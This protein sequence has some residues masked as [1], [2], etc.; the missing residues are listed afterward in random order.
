MRDVNENSAED[1]ENTSLY[2]QLE[3]KLKDSETRY[4]RLFE[5]AKDGVLILDGNSGQIVDVNPYLQEL[6]GYSHN[7]LLGRELWEIG[8]FKNIAASKKAFKELQSKEY[9]HFEDM[10]LETKEGKAIDVE[11]VSNVYLVDH[12]RVIQCNIRNITK[13]KIA[14]RKLH[15]SETRYRRLFETAKDGILILDGNSGQIVDVNP[16]LQELLGYSHNDLLGRELWE[17]GVFKNIAASKKAFKELQ[18]KEYIHFEDMPLETKEGRAIDVEFVSNVYVV[19][20]TKVIQCNIRNITDRKLAEE[21]L[22]KY[23]QQLKELNATKDKLFSIIGHDLRTPF[24]TILSFSELLFENIRK[25]EIDTSLKYIGHINSTAKHTL[26]Q[27]DNLLAWAKTQAGRTYFKP[28]N[29]NLYN[30][31]HGIVDSLNSSALIKNINLDFYLANNIVV[32]ADENMLMTIL[33]NLI[34]NAIKFTNLG[35]K[36]FIQCISKPSQIKI[37]VCDNGV[38]M[39]QETC[40]KLFRIDTTVTTSG[41]ANERG[42]GFGLILC[43]EFVEMNGGKIWVKSK[44]G[45]GSKFTFT[46]PTGNKEQFVTGL[47]PKSNRP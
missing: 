1:P 39:D 7:D 15:D 45:E 16:Y 5:S 32:F 14:E 19:D 18:N 44:L 37:T 26:V 25:V 3:E 46:L 8:V 28:Q 20:H 29:I 2:R 11:F 12:T 40:N 27:L 10:P 35:G 47:N 36:V 31:L 23:H 38:G 21:K 34:S 41:T 42:S 22:A 30:T 9:I 4:R 13:R 24:C 6:L 17:I 43:K 33:Q